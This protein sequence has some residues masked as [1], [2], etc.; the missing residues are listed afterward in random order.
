MRFLRQLRCDWNGEG[1]TDMDIV[2]ELLQ[3]IPLP[4]MAKATQS[5]PAGELADVAGA[6]REQ[7]GKP[8]VVDTIKPG[9]RIAIAVG[10]RGVA[11]IPTLVRVT[12]EEIRRR[13][14]IPFIVP[15][16]GSHGGATAEGQREVLANLGVTEKTAGC[17]ILASME[18]VE[19]GR[20]GSGLPVYIDKNAYG[21][22]GIVVINR[23]KP[24]TAF[25]G[26]C[27]SGMVKM[28][29]IG[30][31]KQK[32]AESCH[33]YSFKYMAEHILLMSEISLAKTPILFGV[34]TV[35][36]AYDKVM[37]VVAVPAH[38][39]VETDKAMLVE[40]KANMPK[41]LIEKFDILIVDQI[42]KDVSGDG[43][44]PNITG[45]Y[46]TPYASGGADIT[47]IVILDLSE[48][49]HGN[50]NGMGAADFV[51]RKLFDKIDYKST[52]ANSLTSTVPRPVAIPMI[53][54]DDRD[55]ILAA[56][57][58]CNNFDLSKA[59]VIRIKDTLHLGDIRISESL[60]PQAK[61]QSMIEVVSAAAE[62]RFDAKGNLI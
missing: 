9:K 57:K 46:P 18:V 32:G 7:L 56:V 59:T 41:F 58:T 55:A 50:A 28:I 37:K 31:G 21:A 4:R 53:L 14:G 47:R 8:G 1:T 30:L 2:K 25:R 26:E 10:S 36:N 43:M 38:Q 42:G 27:E 22:D 35:E 51:T 40:A 20:L 3:G 23:V 44:D 24:H 54:D 62:M 15:A 12:A 52:Y 48:A 60:I 17:D 49:T 45:R 29:T 33:A 19:I 13:G 5:F 11:E 6:L 39:I 16:M 61:E 34:G